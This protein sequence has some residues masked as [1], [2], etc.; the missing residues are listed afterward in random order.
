M[1]ISARTLPRPLDDAFGLRSR[2]LGIVL[3]NLLL[4]SGLT[5]CGGTSPASD[6][7]AYIPPADVA[8][9]AVETA[10]ASW[11]SGK[12]D[13]AA[14]TAPAVEIW[15]SDRA[16]GHVLHAYKI[17][18]QVGTDEPPCFAVRLSIDD[19]STERVV[20]YLVM[21]KS[22][23]WVF[24]QDDFDRISHWEH[25]MEVKDEAE[26]AT[27]AAAPNPDPENNQPSHSHHLERK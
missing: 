21:G 2:A 18:G 1:S 14:S 23:L 4:L 6:R 13:G 27:P 9:S 22:P 26:G 7:G 11:K 3:G 5:G 12:T 20:R 16:E 15:D 17:L 8:R 25:K 24:R 19:P 10:L